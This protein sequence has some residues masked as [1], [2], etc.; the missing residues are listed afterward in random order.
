MKPWT[1]AN[2]KAW[3][4]SLEYRI[5]DIEHYLRRTLTWIEANEIY[6][7]KL[8][9]LCSF[10]TI[11]WVCHMRNEPITKYELFEI[12]GIKNYDQVPDSTFEFNSD[13]EFMELEELLLQIVENN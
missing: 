3:I 1:R 7:D 10:M 9:F 12:L 5:A 8:V 13:Y 6:S 2:T 11:V 4:S